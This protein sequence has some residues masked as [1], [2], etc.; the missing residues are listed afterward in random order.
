MAVDELL[1]HL[2]SRC[3]HRVD[4][5]KEHTRDNLNKV[6]VVFD[7]NALLWEL[8]HR[9]PSGHGVGFWHGGV[10]QHFA[11]TVDKFFRAFLHLG[12]PISVVFGSETKDANLN[13][14]T[15]YLSKGLQS[16]VYDPFTPILG[17]ACFRQ[18][19]A[20][21]EKEFAGKV[22]IQVSLIESCIA[23]AHEAASRGAYAVCSTS[24][25]GLAMGA[26]LLL[27]SDILFQHGSIQAVLLRAED[28][29]RELGL[30]SFQEM[31]LL[32][33]LTGNGGV[34]TNALLPLHTR[35]GAST[36]EQTI[37]A[38]GAYVQGGSLTA[39]NLFPQATESEQASLFQLFEA[40]QSKFARGTGGAISEDEK[41]T[42]LKLEGF[43]ARNLLPPEFLRLASP[44][45][46]AFV[47]PKALDSIAK[48]GCPEAFF[49]GFRKHVYG[50]FASRAGLKTLS[51]SETTLLE[52]KVVAAE[53]SASPATSFLAGVRQV[54]GLAAAD[55]ASVEPGDLF[56][57]AALQL[58]AASG[59][60]VGC[61]GSLLDT[62]PKAIQDRNM[63]VGRLLECMAVSLVLKNSLS[64][65]Q[66][67]QFVLPAH[68]LK[69]QD[70]VVLSAVSAFEMAMYHVLLYNAVLPQPLPE[71]E[72]TDCFDG[73]LMLAVWQLG[74]RKNFKDLLRGG[75]QNT[76]ATQLLAFIGEPALEVEQALLEKINKFRNQALP[77][78]LNH[79]S[80]D[81][82]ELLTQLWA[83]QVPDTASKDAKKK[84]LTMSIAIWQDIINPEVANEGPIDLTVIVDPSELPQT[85]LLPRTGLTGSGPQR[86]STHT[87]HEFGA[88][89]KCAAALRGSREP[90]K[91]SRNVFEPKNEKGETILASKPPFEMILEFVQGQN[92]FEPF[93]FQQDAFQ[94]IF[95]KKNVL[96]TAP[97]GSGK[98]EVAMFAVCTNLCQ[99]SHSQIFYVCP[100][101]APVPQVACEI[102]AR[103]TTDETQSAPLLGIQTNELAIHPDAQVVVTVPQLLR[104]QLV[105]ADAQEQLKNLSLVVLDDIHITANGADYHFWEELILLL[106]KHTRVVV[107][108]SGEG[109]KF[110]KWLESALRDSAPLIHTTTTSSLPVQFASYNGKLTTIPREAFAVP[111]LTSAGAITKALSVDSVPGATT[112]SATTAAAPAA[113]KK[114]KGKAA[115]TPAASTPA[116]ATPAPT[117]DSAAD[118]PAGAL[119]RQLAFHASLKVDLEGKIETPT[120]QKLVGD[121]KA[122]K[123]LP[124]LF[125][126]FEVSDLKAWVLALGA[127]EGLVD[128]SDK[129]E[130]E[131]AASRIQ[132]TGSLDEGLLNS[133][134]A[135]VGLHHSA[136]SVATRLE[137]ERLFRA[138]VLKVLFATPDIASGVHISCASIVLCGDKP[139]AFDA[140]KFRAI[141]GRAGRR[142]QDADGLVIFLGNYEINRVRALLSE[143]EQFPLNTN[144]STNL[145]MDLLTLSY[146]SQSTEQ[147]EQVVSRSMLAF[148]NPRS[149]ERQ[150]R[151]TLQFLFVGGFIDSQAQ[152]T[153]E[154][155]LLKQT[156]GLGARGMVLLD[157]FSAIGNHLRASTD[158]APTTHHL[159][160][161]PQEKEL[162]NILTVFA[163]PRSCFEGDGAIYNDALV[164]EKVLPTE[165]QARVNSFNSRMLSLLVTTTQANYHLTRK[166]EAIKEEKKERTGKQ[167]K[168]KGSEEKESKQDKEAKTN[169]KG[170]CAERIVKNQIR[171]SSDDETSIL[172]GLSGHGLGF[173]NYPMLSQ[174]KEELNREQGWTLCRT[175]IVY[176]KPGRIKAHIIE[177]LEGAPIPATLERWRI[178]ATELQHDLQSVLQA[179]RTCR[180]ANDDFLGSMA[181][182]LIDQVEGLLSSSA[183]DA[184]ESLEEL[185]ELFEGKEGKAIQVF[186]TPLGSSIEQAIVVVADCILIDI[187]KSPYVDS[188]HGGQML[189]VVHMFEQMM[190]QLAG[191]GRTIQIVFYRIL[192]K[193][194]EGYPFGGFVRQVIL[195]SLKQQR[196]F[197][198]VEYDDWWSSALEMNRVMPAFIVVNSN[199]PEF[200]TDS[201][202]PKRLLRHMILSLL[203]DRSSP[204]ITQFTDIGLDNKAGMVFRLPADLGMTT[205]AAHSLLARTRPK[206]SSARVTPMP[207]ADS[208]IASL[209]TKHLNRPRLLLATIACRALLSQAPSDIN[210]E[211]VKL[212]LIH[213]L[214]LEYHLPLADRCQ[215][216]PQAPIREVS[217]FLAQ[218]CAVSTSV[219]R[220]VQPLPFDVS[221][222]DF[223]D[224]RL[225]Y[226]LI[227]LLSSKSLD[228]VL[229]KQLS[230]VCELLPIPKA[231]AS[232][233]FAPLLGAAA[234]S[235]GTISKQTT[236]PVRQAFKALR[237][238]PTSSLL[239]MP[240]RS[241]TQTE[242]KV[243]SPQGGWE[244]EV[245]QEVAAEEKGEDPAAAEERIAAE[246]AR[247]VGP[248][249]RKLK[250]ELEILAAELKGITEEDKTKLAALL[251]A[252]AKSM[253]S[254]KIRALVD[255]IL[256]KEEKVSLERKDDEK[257]K[258]K[259]EKDPKKGKKEEEKV[260]KTKDKEDDKSKKDKKKKEEEV[261]IKEP[262]ALL[263]AARKKKSYLK[264]AQF[265]LS[266]VTAADV[267]L[268]KEVA[269]EAPKDGWTCA[270]CG[271]IN[272]RQRTVCTCGESKPAG[273][274]GKKSKKDTIIESNPWIILLQTLFVW[275]SV[276]T[277]VQF[278]AAE[279]LLQSIKTRHAKE[280]R[281]VS[282]L[283]G[284]VEPTLNY[285][286]DL[287]DF[288]V[289]AQQGRKDLEPGA[290]FRKLEEKLDDF[291]HADKKAIY[292]INTGDPI[293][294]P[295]VM[296]LVKIGREDWEQTH[297]M[298]AALSLYRVANAAFRIYIQHLARD[299]VQALQQALYSLGCSETEEATRAMCQEWC[300]ETK[301]AELSEVWE[302]APAGP[303]NGIGKS[304]TAFQLED[305]GHLLARN[306]NSVRDARVPFFPDGWQKDLLDYVDNR[307]SI[308][309]TAPTSSGKTFISYYCMKSII[310]WNKQ[311]ENAHRKQ[312][313]I[314]VAPTIPLINQAYADLYSKYKN[315]SLHRW[316]PGALSLDNPEKIDILVCLPGSLEKL[317]LAPEW[318]GFVQRLS[319]GYVILDEIHCMGDDDGYDRQDVWERMLVMLPCPF[320]AL[321]ATLANK[322]PLLHW[323]RL[324]HGQDQVKAVEFRERWSHLHTFVFNPPRS[325]GNEVINSTLQAIH[326]LSILAEISDPDRVMELAK[327]TSLAPKDGVKL[328]SELEK[329]TDVPEIAS[330]LK[331][332]KPFF[333][334]KSAIKLDDVK[335]WTN[336]LI[337]FLCTK[338]PRDKFQS[339]ITSLWAQCGQAGRN[340][341]QPNFLDVYFLDLLRNLQKNDFLPGIVFGASH[342]IC[343]SL[344]ETV[345]VSL[346]RNE[347][348]E[349][350]INYLESEAKRVARELELNP[351]N[352]STLNVQ[353]LKI[354]ENIDRAK[355]M[356][357]FSWTEST[358]QFFEKLSTERKSYYTK[359][360]ERI[361]V[362]I[363][364]LSRAAE[365]NQQE[366]NEKR[367]RGDEDGDAGGGREEQKGLRDAQAE[368]L[369]QAREELD[370]VMR[371]MNPGIDR[372][373]SFGIFPRD[374][375]MIFLDRL[376]KKGAGKWADAATGLNGRSLLWDKNIHLRA[377][378]R[379]IG[380]HLPSLGGPFNDLVELGFR[381]GY[382]NVV[383]TDYKSLSYGI[384]MPC[385][386]AIFAGD[387]VGLTTLK[388][389]QCAGR[390]GR[391]GYDYYGNTVLYGVPARKYSM[392]M[393]ADLPAMM[394]SF[395][396]NSTLPLRSSRLSYAGAEDKHAL[397]LATMP[398]FDVSRDYQTPQRTAERTAHVKSY[399]DWC[400]KFGLECGY[401]LNEN[402]PVTGGGPASTTLSRIAAHLFE[403]RPGNFLFCEM[404]RRGVLH[405]VIN[406]V[407]PAEKQ[408][409]NG[410]TDDVKLN[411]KDLHDCAGALVEVLAH[412]FEPIRMN[413]SLPPVQSYGTGE[414][415]VYKQLRPLAAVSPE[416][417]AV[418]K[419]CNTH[420]MGSF[421]RS[422]LERLQPKTETPSPASA[423]VVSVAPTVV[424]EQKEAPVVANPEPEST[425]AKTEQPA[426]TVHTREPTQ[427]AKAA[428][429]PPAQRAPAEKKSSGPPRKTQEELRKMMEEAQ[430]K[431]VAGPGKKAK[432]TKTVAQTA[433]TSATTSA[434]TSTTTS[435]TTTASTA[436]TV[437]T[438]PA[439][440]TAPTTSAPTSA[441]ATP[442]LKPQPPASSASTVPAPTD[443]AVANDDRDELVLDP[444][445]PRLPADR[446]FPFSDEPA[447]QGNEEPSELVA[448]FKQSAPKL[449]LR[450]PLYALSNPTDDFSSNIELK[451]TA[452]CGLPEDI[453]ALENNNKFGEPF[454][455]NAYALTF[456]HNPDG[457][458]LTK[459]ND[460]P[461]KDVWG[462][463][464]RWE[465][466]TEELSQVLNQA[467]VDPENDLLCQAM[468]VLAHGMRKRAVPGT[469]GKSNHR[470]KRFKIGTTVQ[471]RHP[472]YAD[473]EKVLSGK[474]LMVGE[475][476]DGHVVYRIAYKNEYEKHGDGS[477][478]DAV[479]DGVSGRNVFLVSRF[480]LGKK[481]L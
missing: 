9:P 62:T 173:V 288:L 399:M 210:I 369:A 309:V 128:G 372:R 53:G 255:M 103:F 434:T 317:L 72:V 176:W 15:E 42:E 338:L 73:R 151:W 13:V 347:M 395:Y 63:K 127:P 444:F 159:A 300:D 44:G 236:E 379:G 320:I 141:C 305:A 233:S 267:D 131:A 422:L 382:L 82:W 28:A 14:A 409:S 12:I 75:T 433:S 74:D 417:A 348:A 307:K 221:L 91:C 426:V 124:A 445:A 145:I 405:H 277:K 96:C 120:L 283:S 155:T 295:L 476:P 402:N 268:P 253:I 269:A 431:K 286:R 31:A 345:V 222:T 235:A 430:Q 326:P 105:S 394:P 89:Q 143:P 406:A 297:L 99:S 447:P 181:V 452:R 423:A 390:A 301:L 252:T 391:R 310:K 463:T 186:W 425:N 154:S 462:V 45:K 448:A 58:V 424:K 18:T 375:N 290:Y 208:L 247:V 92:G 106:P 218:L 298:S 26:D 193:L 246:R 287:R 55:D 386:T 101:A 243:A 263:E 392:L 371:I 166:R 104:Q 191:G 29:R 410:R 271:T 94:A 35:L 139:E 84:Q 480:L 175:P 33:T 51:V 3:G 160:L 380:L 202:E 356:L 352:K 316:T 194:W 184:E 332:L 366:G 56:A 270:K 274:I 24:S 304:Y 185:T 469:W 280:T 264:R 479:V 289:I 102:M 170:V 266:N 258:K 260:K 158:A 43:Q 119:E 228:A 303:I 118:T 115:P 373:H 225:Y 461:E 68:K 230:E 474:V 432:P 404:L 20:A 177:V 1:K 262:V 421:K 454:P 273:D 189:Q 10:Y 456:F 76:K 87:K 272:W 293:L 79:E 59:S 19:L 23:A 2:R 52:S 199:T 302:P 420:A 5:K 257:A 358:D 360:I 153:L 323:L 367:S 384:N 328:Y 108:G 472:Q 361:K 457:A 192:E 204:H 61:F 296:D 207:E 453:P 241:A 201:Q 337:S 17:Q 137:M 212:F 387:S 313:A 57:V 315:A 11:A 344:L 163:A 383:I 239:V 146:L 354:N 25:A 67:S 438:T 109:T 396:L 206:P 355:H 374:D 47:L 107:L 7:G 364:E 408:S 412:L 60:L 276:D 112:T 223:I 281:A 334:K 292:K 335:L 249:E 179:A 126:G 251:E 157:V 265:L 443:K 140:N 324:I 442:V 85:T 451:M 477:L 398:N 306:V 308:L 65:E 121:L 41:A 214:L 36:T 211:L 284:A 376:A 167:K 389:Q 393:T 231:A 226:K 407:L 460:I 340:T 80:S 403:F 161:R 227:E 441:P 83:E 77:A 314:Y 50:L 220:S 16:D 90:L 149:L 152:P 110:H 464:R 368:A 282:S 240:T 27:V 365:R 250:P 130:L 467:V 466:L 172:E 238:A 351:E 437:T 359:Y 325:R 188:Q 117:T 322:K 134:R 66:R 229:T 244:A 418:V 459:D 275:S 370:R 261:V 205:N 30:S 449:Q 39:A 259:K 397:R 343:E 321:S 114:A 46:P 446:R 136:L 473:K 470:F 216:V 86:I 138:G 144:L 242:V 336:H 183:R 111:S 400:M 133:L 475:T 245:T 362:K 411:E 429:E 174:F 64:F 350:E 203:L 164:Q 32:W 37:A 215:D 95:D 468:A 381:K 333:A 213:T 327:R 279:K 329:L 6:G 341:I 98:T 349:R 311:P 135:G 21:L 342:A 142:P 427:D 169:Q 187:L 363:E 450:C 129:K 195:Q 171:L 148:E 125:I 165:A 178:T 182:A 97:A 122:Q 8:W 319:R 4:L 123:R 162:L 198:V 200:S 346:E 116:E 481:Q 34:P 49:A 88:L 190:V 478:K 415:K 291:L 197:D 339:V 278:P 70:Q 458:A 416:A 299:Q 209:T 256:P 357:K 248:A 100:S 147:A 419:F 294:I 237:L 353:L 471:F 331:A 132:S 318:A 113:K 414:A 40:S 254:G 93:P 436:S 377:L 81:S 217:D 428:A 232:S 285:I 156:S 385:R 180:D 455:L 330:E 150:L 69:D 312:S 440:A 388:Y 234:K 38:V 378:S 224:A 435:A 401:L 48:H 439:T 168:T 196:R 413:R 54:L 78:P 465:L 71:P 219:L 22:K